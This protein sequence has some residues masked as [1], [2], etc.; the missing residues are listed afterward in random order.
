M[1][2]IGGRLGSYNSRVRGLFEEYSPDVFV[3]GHSHILK[4]AFDKAFNLLYMNPG[5]CGHHGFHKFRTV[6]SFSISNDKIY[7]IQAI[8]LGKRGRN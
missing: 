8:E 7:D 4:V 1:V 3:C 6:L 2:H 5:A